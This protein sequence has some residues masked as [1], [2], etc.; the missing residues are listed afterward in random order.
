MDDAV[1]GR[2]VF[3]INR[4]RLLDTDAARRFFRRVLDLAEWQG[5]VS[6]EHFSVDGS[7]IGAWASHKSFLPRD[8]GSGPDKPFGRNP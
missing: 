5:F 8:G 3:S 7:M 1:W 4:D 2:T 6:D